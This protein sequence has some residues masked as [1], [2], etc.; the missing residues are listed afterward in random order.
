MSKAISLPIE[1]PV[2]SAHQRLKEYLSTLGYDSASIE[3]LTPDASTREYF[4]IAWRSGP[5]V[6]AIYKEPFDP[7]SHPFVDVTNLFA[8]AGL[9]VPE[10]YEVDGER[11]IIVQED[12]GDRQLSRFCQ[13]ATEDDREDYMDR[14][15]RLIADMQAASGLARELNCVASKLA[16][17]EEKL[18]WELNFFFQHYFGS[19]RGEETN[20][21][22]FDS[23]KEELRSIAVELSLR[24]RVLCHRDYHSSNLIVDKQGR[25]RIIDHQDARMGPATYDLVSLLLDRQCEP[26]SLALLRARRLFFL[27][28]RQLRGLDVL[29]PDEFA[30]E[31]RLMTIQRGLKAVGTFS[32]QT[33]VCGR[34][35]VYGHFINPTLQVVLQ[36]VEWMDRYPAIRNV[37]RERVQEEVKFTKT[38]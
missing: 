9:P 14:A 16:F 19:L 13:V 1:S 29:D 6:A 37:I 4:R 34:G 10:I 2:S 26:P 3:P 28:Q 23:L 36:A 24:P 30:L 8:K 38:V 22:R 7:A 12:L 20:S 27:E 32:Y 35:D 5:A 31:F 33:S 18:M 25:L 11:G 21:T 17:D 15:V